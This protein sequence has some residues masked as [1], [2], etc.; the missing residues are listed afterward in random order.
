MFLGG[1]ASF[2]KVDHFGGQEAFDQAVM[3][4]DIPI[5][6]ADF[7]TSG[8]NSAGGVDMDIQIANTSPKTIKY[9]NFWV[10]AYNRVGDTVPDRISG[11]STRRVGYTGPMEPLK[12]TAQKDFF[13]QPTSPSIWSNV[14]YNHSIACATI[15]EVEVIYMD[16]TRQR[17]RDTKPLMT[18]ETLCRRYRYNS[19]P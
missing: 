5:L 7:G 9:V 18:R 19:D 11:R 15:D 12:T 6:I 2:V 16:D 14:W 13:G 4:P 17:I 8:A 1:C 10:T 3:N